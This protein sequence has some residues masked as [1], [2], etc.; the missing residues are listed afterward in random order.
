MVCHLVYAV[1]A[2]G[3][4]GK[5]SYRISRSLQQL[6]LP[7]SFFGSRNN[8]NTDWWPKRSPFENT[9]H[10]FQGLS[11][12]IPTLLYNLNEQIH[13]R[14]ESDDI[15]LGHPYFPFQ[16]GGQG[17]TELSL[18]QSARPKV[19]G[20]ISPL[21]C[22]TDIETVHI[23][24][25]YLEAI[26][27]LLPQSDILFAIMGQYWWDQWPSSSFAHWMPKMVR[28]DMA[29]DTKY[30]PRVKKRFNRPGSRGYL[31]IGKNDPMKGVGFLSTLSERFGD[32]RFGWIG[33]GA[34]IPGVPR[35]S[36]A[37]ALTGEFMSKIAEEYDFFI[38]P[39]QADP[40]P[41]TI[42][43]S[44]SWG[45]PV[46]CTPQSGYYETAYMRNIFYDDEDRSI[47]VLRELQYA[48]ESKLTRMADEARDVVEQQ[49]TWN[50]FVDTICNGLNIT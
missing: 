6:G 47:E 23:N 44:M 4:V 30:F 38:S 25:S 14:F 2:K 18:E 3:Y 34:E 46:V 26:D 50:R 41:T 28:L 5:L 27:K 45:F 40:N 12:R 11:S 43:E 36:T 48:D 20:L 49:Y 21:H 32:T 10:I 33:S 7:V 8:P 24:K 42:L 19:F 17:V 39:S 22:N 9:K 13:C 16:N 1:P 29:I 35:V 15:F 31:Y 37:R